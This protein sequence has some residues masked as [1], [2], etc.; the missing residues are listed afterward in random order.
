MALPAGPGGRYSTSRSAACTRWPHRAHQ[1]TTGPPSS[2]PPH[3]GQQ[4]CHPEL[5]IEASITAPW[6]ASASWAAAFEVALARDVAG[7]ILAIM[8]QPLCFMTP[9]SASEPAVPIP[10]RYDP[11]GY[12]LLVTPWSP[13]AGDDR[14]RCG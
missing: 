5:V 1:N 8:G 10:R 3:D 9:R 11:A 12:T 13:T 6:R 4:P 7:A 14:G 2:P